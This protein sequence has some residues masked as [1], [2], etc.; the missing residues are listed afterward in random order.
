M[1]LSVFGGPTGREL[2][3]TVEIT[4]VDPEESVGRVSGPR[5]AE[6]RQDDRVR[7]QK[8][9]RR[10]ADEPWYATATGREGK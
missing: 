10:E 9:G 8:D 5:A 6:V 1:R 2:L 4:H 7:P 3:G